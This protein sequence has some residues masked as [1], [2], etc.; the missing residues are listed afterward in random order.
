MGTLRKDIKHAWRMF[1]E[2]KLFTATAI[3]ALT[4]GIGVNIAV[5]SVVNAVLLKPVPFPEPDTLVQLVNTTN[6]TA[7]GGASSPAK[8]MHWRAQT[9]VLEQV[10]AVRNIE[11]NLE[12]GDLPE[13][14]AVVQTTAE[15]F[16]AYR[17]PLA[18]GRWFTAEEALPNGGYIVVLSYNFW[19]QRLG[20]D[21][22]V[23]GKSVTLSGNPYTIVGV[24]GR[25][26]DVRDF[27]S[28]PEVWVPFQLDPN[29]ADQGH[30]FQTVGRLKP[31]VSLERAQAQLMA[32]AAAYR[33]RYTVA[34]MPEMAGFSTITLQEAL[35]RQARPTLLVALGAVGFVLLI[36]C[37][38]VANLLLVR[39]TGRRRELAVRVA[40]GA[41]RWRIVRQLLTES[42]M[43]S[44]AGG[45]MGLVAGYLGMRVL[46]TVNTAGLPRLGQAGALLGLDSN[47]VLFT[48]VL[49][50][51]TGILFGSIPALVASRAD[52]NAVIK[53]SSSRSGSGFRQNKTRSTLVLVEV[54]LAVVLLV[55]ASLLIRTSLSLNAVDPGY[56]TENVLVLRTSL[57]GPRFQTTAAVDET[58]RLALER[59]RRI[60]GVSAASMTCCV[61]L[62][63]GYGLPFN[64]LGRTNE[65]PF[66]GGSGI[67]MAAPGYF[68]TFEIPVIRGRAF[69]ETDTASSPPVM[70]ISQ[71]LANQFWPDGDPLADQV[72]IG[73]GPGD[74][75]R[76]KEPVRRIIGVVGDV[77]AGGIAQ[78]PG[79]MIYLPQAQLPDEWHAYMMVSGPMGWVVR[80]SAEPRTVSQQ[81]QAIIRETTGVPV[82]NIQNMDEIVSVNTS[83]QRLNMLLMTIFGGSA[84]VLA[85]IGIY[86]LMAYSVQHRTQEIG[87]RLA[88]GAEAKRV[89]WSVVGQGMTLV[90]IGIVVGIVAALYLATFLAAALYGVQPRDALV[91]VGVPVV[92]AATAFASVWIA[93]R[94]ASR[95]DPL[96]A[97]RY[98]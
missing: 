41:G 69:N 87:I 27:G 85:A 51:V 79:P 65:G 75:R 89:R 11:M 31:G 1:F 78:D 59:V 20:S 5:F 8:Y 2:N 81:I 4:L 7:A 34:A 48:L 57:T 66:T 15:Y 96:Q 82:T 80:T 94:R 21:P 92:L 74:T 88:L 68:D 17:P 97:L 83:R 86:G 50:I 22:S 77:R 9:D 36:A 72:K 30:Y 28:A 10:A 33:D 26:F 42:L 38:N 18:M 67:H 63:G 3:A 58:A 19:A 14:I 61:P 70:I 16:G 76:A 29:T 24:V 46:L 54:S 90:G 35:V 56:T 39:A 47:I 37:A 45:V 95:I 43:L 12:Q 55:G 23:L 6:G 53:D 25:E 52:L 60:P 40:L 32:S 62:Q 44:F 84:L 71:A 91:F 49:V 13:A 93:A 98:E 73:M 64:I